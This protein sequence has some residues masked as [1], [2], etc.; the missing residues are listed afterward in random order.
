[1]SAVGLFPSFPISTCVEYDCFFLLCVRPERPTEVTKTAPHFLFSKYPVGVAG[2][3]TSN[4]MRVPKS[5]QQ[6]KSKGV[7][8]GVKQVIEN[9]QYVEVFDLDSNPYL[10][11]GQTGTHSIPFS[12]IEDAR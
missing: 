5:S 12:D 6:V 8:Y 1:M 4:T 2:E 3:K 10:T 11:F 9:E 7:W